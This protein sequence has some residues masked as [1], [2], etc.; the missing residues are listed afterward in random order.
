MTPPTNALALHSPQPLQPGLQSAARSVSWVPAV[1]PCV[2]LSVATLI[3][4]I[5]DDSELRLILGSGATFHVCPLRFGKQ[6]RLG[7]SHDTMEELPMLKTAN[8]IALHLYETRSVSLK[9]RNG[10]TTNMSCIV[11]DTKYPIVSVNRLRGGGFSACLGKGNC[12][13]KDGLRE[14]VAPENNDTSDRLWR[15]ALRGQYICHR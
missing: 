2:G 9:L 15:D 7:D 13:E 1:T 10:V 4:G 8:D 6:F 14:E 11:C 3:C 12:I 5:H